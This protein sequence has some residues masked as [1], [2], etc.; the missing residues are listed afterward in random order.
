MF[1]SPPFVSIVIPT[2]NRWELAATCL[3]SAVAQTNHDYEIIL[4]DNSTDLDHSERLG[5]LV[6]QVA[7]YCDAEVRYLQPPEPL[8]MADNW[9]YATRHATGRYV[10]VLTD[11]HVI[12][13]SS[14]AVWKRIVEET[15]PDLLI[16]NVRSG[17]SSVS[18]F[19]RTSP[20]DGQV[21]QQTPL[22]V[23]DRFLQFSGWKAESMFF[24]ELP[25]SLNCL[26][27]R[28]LADKI[29]DRHKTLYRPLSP[30]NTSAFL[31]LAAA[32]DVTY[33]NLPFYC[34]WGNQSNGEGSAIHGTAGYVSTYPGMDQFA[35]CPTRID[36]VFNT[37]VSDFL[38]TQRLEPALQQRDYSRPGYY[39]S[40]YREIQI[41]ELRGSPLD[42]IGMRQEWAAAIADLPQSERDVVESGRLELETRDVR[43]R[44]TRR[45]LYRTGLLSM[46][47]TGLEHLRWVSG[48]VRGRPSYANVLEAVASTDQYLYCQTPG[49]SA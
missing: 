48:R 25:R 16:W 29:R 3:Q 6:Q 24:N 49:A 40:L 18:G 11:R 9:E 22:H 1:K 5:E 37:I 17:Y 7:K 32:S 13:P 31:F 45:V 8:N 27:R 38:E 14:V 15:N 26:H 12:R 42:T 30:D 23:L 44:R 4:S 47:R 2:R 20:F 33:V 10:A 35:G 46:L 21:T 39:L 41:K 19:E 28:K 43:T 34:S 36:S